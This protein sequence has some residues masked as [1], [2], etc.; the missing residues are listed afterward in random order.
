MK[1]KHSTG[2]LI[3]ILTG[4]LFM[5]IIPACRQGHAP[6]HQDTGDTHGGIEN[7]VRRFGSVI[8]LKPEKYELYRE[9]HAN[10]WPGVDSLL[11]VYHIRN[12]SIYHRDG[13]LFSYLEYTGNDWE[14]DMALLGKEQIIQEWWKLTDPCQDPVESAAEGEWWAPMEELYHLE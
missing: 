3:W 8:K 9:L 13:Y 12:F 10:P 5:L 6:R 7:G 14:A 2:I 11:K 1:R 4:I